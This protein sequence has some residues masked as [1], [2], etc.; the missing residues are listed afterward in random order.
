MSRFFLDRPV[1]AWVVAILIMLA[2]ALSIP[3]M[4]VEQYP[5][6]APPQISVTTFYPGASADTVQNSVTQVIEQQLTGIDNLRYFS[7]TSD[8]TGRVEIK[9]TLEPGTDPDIAQVQVQNKVQT[10]M[11]LLPAAVQSQEIGRAHV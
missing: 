6:L 2:G 10:A 1:F 11:P 4:P 8:A 5:T 3:Q 9:V 7:S